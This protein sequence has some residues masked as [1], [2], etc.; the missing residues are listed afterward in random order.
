MQC[1]IERIASAPSTAPRPS[2]PWILAE[3]RPARKCCS[4][5]APVAF[6]NL[7]KPLRLSYPMRHVF[8]VH[9][10]RMDQAVPS[11]PDFRKLL[12]LP[13]GENIRL[14]SEFPLVR[15]F[16]VD[17]RVP[18]TSLYVLLNSVPV[19]NQ[20]IQARRLIDALGVRHSEQA[21]Q[22][23]CGDAPVREEVLVVYAEAG[24]FVV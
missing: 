19:K 24:S 17:A 20:H 8:R 11:H 1:S 7:E 3:S 18:K 10:L 13:K 23:Q 22:Q 4:F 6:E 21:L 15:L 2:S 14:D 9:G 16:I 12:N 5:A